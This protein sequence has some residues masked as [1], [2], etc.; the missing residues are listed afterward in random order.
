MNVKGLE[1][2]AY[3]CRATKITGLGYVTANRGGDHITAYVQGPTFLDIPFL[4]VEEST[5]ED[6]TK[7]NPLEAKVVK[8]MEDALTT[9]DA[10]GV[11]K[12]MG[13]ALM[14]EDIV[15]VI[16]QPRGGTLTWKSSDRPVSGSSTWPGRS[17]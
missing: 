9:F 5:I 3:D 11:C 13:M 6:V 14:A 12:F 10:L 2:P 7:E 15:P 16:A 4:I 8:D 17:M 1:L